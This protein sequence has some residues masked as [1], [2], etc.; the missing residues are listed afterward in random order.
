MVGRGLVSIVSSRSKIAAPAVVVASSAGQ[1][2]FTSALA[3]PFV[4]VLV[5][6]RLSVLILRLG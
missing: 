4:E 6:D 5:M 2:L 3:S 1:G